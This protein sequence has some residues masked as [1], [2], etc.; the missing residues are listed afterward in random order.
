MTVFVQENE[1]F[2]EP[3][4]QKV[5]HDRGLSL[6]Q[7]LT[8]D[9]MSAIVDEVERVFQN[10]FPSVSEYYHPIGKCL[11]MNGLICEFGF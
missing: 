2:S 6:I 11:E 8:L 1:K 9:K 10:G 5:I 7:S 4:F 3:S